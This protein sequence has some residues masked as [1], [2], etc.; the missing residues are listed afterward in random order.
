MVYGVRE[1]WKAKT[2]KGT[3]MI[4]GGVDAIEEKV[5]SEISNDARRSNVEKMVGGVECFGPEGGW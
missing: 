5:W 3:K 4:I 1:I 2:S